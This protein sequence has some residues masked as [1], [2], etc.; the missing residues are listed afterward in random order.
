M[1]FFT[2]TTIINDNPVAVQV[3][4]PGTRL[5]GV[6]MVK[7]RTIIRSGNDKSVVREYGLHTIVQRKGRDGG[8]AMM[9]QNSSA[10]P[11]P[12]R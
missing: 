5:V 4:R 12:Q 11:Y 10:I 3:V 1:N 2:I 8:C 6:S 7:Q 9:S